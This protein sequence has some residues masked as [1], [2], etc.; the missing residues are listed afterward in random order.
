M[1]GDFKPGCRAAAVLR[2]PHA[3][4]RVARIDVERA[5]TCPGVDAVLTGREVLALVDPFPVAVA[6]APAYYPIAIDRVRFVGEPVAVVVATDRYAAR[7]AAELTEV[8]YDPLPAVMDP[9]KALANGAPLL[10]EEFKTNRAYHWELEGGD[11]K[12]AFKQADHVVKQRLVNHRT[13]PM[14]MEPRGVLADFHTGDRRLTVW[15]S[16]QIPHLV[17]SFLAGDDGGPCAT[18]RTV[19]GLRC[20]DLQSAAT[21]C[22]WVSSSAASTCRTITSSTSSRWV[23]CGWDLRKNRFRG[24]SPRADSNRRASCR[25]RR[26]RR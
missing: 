6:T 19:C 12:K 25:S 7:D 9:E 11:V 22:G 23:T 10:Y 3:H 13:I 8:D 1:A 20:V 16:T 15:S 5:R 21:D 4:A 2:S 17:R 26:T 18:G 14:P 24:C